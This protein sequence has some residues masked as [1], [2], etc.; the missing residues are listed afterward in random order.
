MAVFGFGGKFVTSIPRAKHVFNASAQKGPGSIDVRS[1]HDMLHQSDSEVAAM[2]TFPG[3]LSHSNPAINKNDVLKMMDARIAALPDRDLSEQAEKVLWSTM[4]I[5]LRHGGTLSTDAAATELKQLLSLTSNGRSQ[6]DSNQL[7][8]QAPQRSAAE[9][10]G[11]VTAIQ[12]LLVD[13]KR[14]DALAAAAANDMW[15]HAL[16][17]SSLFGPEKYNETIAAF[18]KSSLPEGSPMRMLFLLLAGRPQDAFGSGSSA[19]GELGLIGNKWREN[20]VMILGNRSRS[21]NDAHILVALGDALRDHPTLISASHLCYLLAH[22]DSSKP[23]LLEEI[24]DPAAR[25]VLLGADHR[26]KPDTYAQQISSLQL[27]EL[28]EYCKR[29]ASPGFLVPQL[30]IYKFIYASR[31][32][33]VGL[34]ARAWKYIESIKEGI[35]EQKGAYK[36]PRMFAHQ[37]SELASRLE[38][39]VTKTAPTK[40]KLEVASS[41]IFSVFGK[42]LSKGLG[43]IIGDD[44]DDE[45]NSGQKPAAAS[46]PVASSAASAPGVISPPAIPFVDPKTKQHAPVADMPGPMMAPVQ[47][48]GM[49]IS[50]APGISQPAPAPMPS[51]A[52]IA[53]TTQTNVPLAVESPSIAPAP[54]PFG[55]PSTPISASAGRK[56]TRASSKRAAAV[57]P[58]MGSSFSPAVS[59]GPPVP[60]LAPLQV[61]PTPAPVPESPVLA[62]ETPSKPHVAAAQPEPAPAPVPVPALDASKKPKPASDSSDGFKVPKPAV[63]PPKEPAPS[64]LPASEPLPRR[65]TKKEQDSDDE[66]DSSFKTPAKVTKGSKASQP[67]A[68]A[69]KADPSAPATPGRLGFLNPLNWFSRSASKAPK[70][71]EKKPVE[72]KLGQKMSRYYNEELKMWVNPGEEEEAKKRK[73]ALTAAPPVSKKVAASAPVTPAGSAPSTPMQAHANGAA[74]DTPGDAGN[75]PTSLST[76]GGRAGRASRAAGGRG[77]KYVGQNNEIIET[78]STPQQSSAPSGSQPTP[79]PFPRMAGSS[80]LVSVGG[81]SPL[82][83]VPAGGSTFMPGA[84]SF[85]AFSAIAAAR[86]AEALKEPDTPQEEKASSSSKSASK[87]KKGKNDDDDDSYNIFNSKPKKREP[88][89]S[90]PPETKASSKASNKTKKEPEKEPEAEKPLADDAEDDSDQ[91]ML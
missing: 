81:S 29:L 5:L 37:F 11:A 13:G 43:A 51:G 42:A 35:K 25:L 63:K 75:S 38:Q 31:L 86:E 47:S 48:V 77:R 49:P 78:V 90:P 69:S 10:S 39:I 4:R 80:P 33:E 60:V 28:Y 34:N 41:K 62:V 21:S 64:P 12:S 56:S 59:S 44:A 19:S 46:Q 7:V 53:M 18:V 26:T 2:R 68:S 82:I 55:L 58:V 15:A 88:A 89:S 17:I 14:E 23:I 71:G 24:A 85:D 1:L 83:S 61:T 16:L 20:L 50:V 22:V 67:A 57:A 32:A 74:P 73:E 79:I 76:A 8:W 52:P 30:Q 54:L 65:E 27:S 84:M 72:V 9:L 91:L 87:A 70:P 45:N 3:P 66:D 6:A 40:G 36:Y